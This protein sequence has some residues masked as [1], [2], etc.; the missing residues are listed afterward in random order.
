MGAS[1]VSSQ[2]G[3]L[4][5]KNGAGHTRDHGLSAH[6]EEPEATTS[7]RTNG[8]ASVALV[9]PDDTSRARRR[10]YTKED[11]LRILRLVDACTER[12]QVGAILRREGIYYSTLRDFEK[13]RAQG[14]LA[15][16]TTKGAPT[17]AAGHSDRKRIADLEAKNKRLEHKLAQA[18]LVIDIQKKV[19]LLLGIT[20]PEQTT[21]ETRTS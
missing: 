7:E 8:G 2:L 4:F 5:V 6:L 16:S 17:Q 15:S 18:E 11:K 13:Q 1:I 3:S 14:R 12:G 20:L 9:E 21:D 10:R 19:S